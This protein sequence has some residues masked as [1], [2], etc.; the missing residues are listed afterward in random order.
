MDVEGMLDELCK[1]WTSWV[2][3]QAL[4]AAK[5]DQLY[6]PTLIPPRGRGK[7]ARQE[8]EDLAALADAY[9]AAMAERG[10]PRRAYRGAVPGDDLH[11][12]RVI[13]DARAARPFSFFD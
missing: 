1:R 12:P 9:D 7:A 2:S 5:D 11:V 8:R 10:D 6:C 4:L 13:A 3:F